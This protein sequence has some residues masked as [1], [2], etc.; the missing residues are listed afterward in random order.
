MFVEG[1]K[2]SIVSGVRPALWVLMGAVGFVLLVVCA[3]VANLLLV[4]GHTRM[5]EVA[6]RRALGAGRWRVARL[7]RL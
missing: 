2:E 4:R 7:L 1:L 6:I 5:G 3:N